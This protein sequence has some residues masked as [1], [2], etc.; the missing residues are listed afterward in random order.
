MTHPN[1][2]LPLVSIVMA[3]YNGSQFL[4]AQLDSIVQQTYPNIE[5]LVVDDCSKD[6]TVEIL[7]KYAQQYKNIRVV[8]NTTN[9]GYVKNFEKACLLATGDYISFCDQDDVWDLHKTTLL[10]EAIGDYPMIYCDSAFVDQDLNSMHRNHSDLKNLQS[11]DNCLYFAT[12][13]CVGGHA[14][15]MKKE[16]VPF[17][18]PFPVEMPHD[19]WVAFIATLHGGIKYFD[20]PLVK[21]RQHGF[22]VTKSH[23]DE[24]IKTVETR[25]RLELFY[26]AC[27]PEWVQERKVLGQLIQGYKSRSL[28][29]NFLRMSLFFKYKH[30][31]LAMKKRNEFRK[32]LFCIKMFFKLRLHVA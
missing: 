30:Y 21:W 16:L 27:G 20:Q 5:I 12:D 10:M 9:L 29:N 25:K 23:K 4:E 14:L 13:N 6:N 8:V 26:N 1:Q 3:T 19:L 22:N 28:S 7:H 11:F 17:T 18:M 2:E 31:L 24:S 32:F 15:I